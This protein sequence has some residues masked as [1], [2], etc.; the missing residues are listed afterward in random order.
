MPDPTKKEEP[1][2]VVNPRLKQD[3]NDFLSYLDK[4]GVRGKSDLDKFGAGYKLFDEYVK[5]NPGTSLSRQTLPAIRKEILNY[6]TWVL[7]ENRK[8]MGSRKASLGSG[9]TEDNFMRHVVANEK[10]SDPNYPGM[11]LTT[12]SFPLSYLNTFVSDKLIKTENQ[13]FAIPKK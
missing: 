9:V 1:K 13:G 7:D 12:T 5:N 8:P 3:W 10:T 2:P 11:H 6:R 4:K